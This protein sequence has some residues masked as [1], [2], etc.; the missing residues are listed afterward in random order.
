MVKEYFTNFVLF[1]SLFNFS[2]LNMQAQSWEWARMGS[3]NNQTAGSSNCSD[4][5]GNVYVTGFFTE[6]NITF[7][8][9]TLQNNSPYNSLFLV[10]YNNNGDVIWAKTTS[11]LNTNQSETRGICCD[12]DGNVLLTGLYWQSIKLGAITVSSTSSWGLYDSFLAK[13]DSAGNVLWAKTVGNG[14]ILTTAVCSDVIGNV[15]LTGVFD[16]DTLRLGSTYLTN[17]GMP[18]WSWDQFTIK[19]NS[20]GSEIWA[21]SIGGPYTEGSNS[22]CTDLKQNVFVTGSFLSITCDIDGIILN[23]AASDSTNDIFIVKYDHDGNLSWANTYGGP[24]IDEGTDVVSDKLGNVY[25]TGFFR[26]DSLYFGSL[27]IPGSGYNIPNPQ[28]LCGG[29]TFLLKLDSI[30]NEVWGRSYDQTFLNLGKCASIDDSGYIYVS[31]HFAGSLINSQGSFPSYG[32]RSIYISKYDDTGNLIYTKIAGGENIEEIYS[33]CNDPSGSVFITGY[34]SSSYIDFGNI[35]L[36]FGPLST[37]TANRFL[38]TAKLNNSTLTTG[39][40]TESRI[41]FN[42][43]PNPTSGLLHIAYKF[44]GQVEI[45]LIDLFGRIII[46]RKENITGDE[47][48]VQL[49]SDNIAKGTY[50]LSIADIKG[51]SSHI[52]VVE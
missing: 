33:I 45:K 27:N 17:S 46:N 43:Y 2:I 32:G 29:T 26:G 44:S 21:K 52:V 1:F 50:V 11:N 4:K 30:G 39:M 38:Y 35:H 28:T 51:S 20:A 49:N 15:Y 40:N 19:Y 12:P 14:S 10:K 3:P 36:T 13:F 22:I 6:T 37:T 41:D 18:S 48:L 9:Y 24:S 47:L 7:G 8:N 31:G 5:F 23:N 25:I 16:A 34:S 42:V